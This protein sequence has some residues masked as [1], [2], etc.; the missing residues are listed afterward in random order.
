MNV[1]EAGLSPRSPRRAALVAGGA[2]LGAA[3]TGLPVRATEVVPT[4]P[5]GQ[6]SATLT[7]QVVALDQPYMWNRL[8]AWQPQGMMYALMGDVVSTDVDT[9]LRAGKVELRPGKRP[10]PLTLRMNAG[11]CLAIEFTNLL[12]PVK[13]DGQQPSTRTASIHVDGLQLVNSI[14]DDGSNVG[15]NFQETGESGLVAPGGT[16]TY[17][18]YAETEGTHLFYSAAAMTGGE[19]NNSSIAAGLFGAINVEPA[20]AEWYRSQLT[21]EEMD[22]ATVGTT[23]GELPVEPRAGGPPHPVDSRRRRD[24]ARRPERDHHGPQPRLVLGGHVPCG[25]GEP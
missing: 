7:A 25:R 10:R 3:L 16:V 14:T 15:R 5:N 8:G 19:G 17:T 20:G 6:C 21:R 4:T 9:S 2:L 11:Q 12:D 1:M 18:L 23:D 22:L 13:R 24:R